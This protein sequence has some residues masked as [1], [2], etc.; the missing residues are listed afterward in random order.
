MEHSTNEQLLARVAQH[1]ER[2]AALGVQVIQDSRYSKA[3]RNE[4][5]RAVEEYYSDVAK[6]WTPEDG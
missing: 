6:Y 3:E 5:T 1:R 2:M 4:L